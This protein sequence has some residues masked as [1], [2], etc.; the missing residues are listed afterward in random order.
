M[1]RKVNCPKCGTEIDENTYECSLCH[2]KVAKN[3]P[4]KHVSMLPVWKQA[5][6]FLIGFG[7]F[8]LLAFLLSLAV[9]G[10]AKA[11]LGEGTFAYYNFVDSYRFVGYI[12]F[13]SYLLI[14]AALA[15]LIIK[16]SYEVLRS[17]KKLKPLIAGISGLLIILLFNALYTN[18][19]AIS[20]VL[21]TNNANENAIN[22]IVYQYPVLSI[23]V[24]GLIGPIVEEL[25]YRVGVF[26]FFSRINKILAYVLTVLIFTLI[27]FDFSSSQ[28]IVN[29]LLNIPLY[30]SAAIV[31]CYL[32]DHYAFAGSVYC[33]VLNNVLSIV[34]TI[35][36]TRS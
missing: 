22:N 36:A 2:H 25:T 35:A 5:L 16:D 12:N 18:I 10:I 6:L 26:S 30:A 32:Y 13:A 8:Q 20:G 19:L 14:F 33:H 28:A 24:F 23:L 11:Q 17:F 7:A 3:A 4:F 34:T 1:F 9:V 27:H 31:L 15:A 29:E 21:I